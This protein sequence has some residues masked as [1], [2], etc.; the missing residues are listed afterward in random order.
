MQKCLCED[1][2]RSKRGDSACR[3]RQFGCTN[4]DEDDAGAWCN[5]RNPGCDQDRGAA[6]ADCGK[7]NYYIASSLWC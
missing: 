4:C 1:V 2:W 7:Q 3:M 5:I 6:F